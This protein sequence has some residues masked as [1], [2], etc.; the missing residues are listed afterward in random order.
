MEWISCK[1]RL[2]EGNEL[3]VT[4][5]QQEDNPGFRNYTAGRWYGNYWNH[6]HSKYVT[7]WMPLLEP[8]HESDNG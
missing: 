4:F 5:A 2:P 8:P 3:V 1:D 6:S 7:H